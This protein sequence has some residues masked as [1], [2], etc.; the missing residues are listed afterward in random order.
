[1]PLLYPGANR[2]GAERFAVRGRT[3]DAS[4][5]RH[6]GDTGL[7]MHG[8]PAARGPWEVQQAGPVTVAATLDW[9]DPAFPFPHRVTVGVALSEQA[10]RLV[11][12]VSGDAPIAFGFHPYLRL[13]GV[14]R[15]GWRVELP[16]RRRLVLGD[17]RLP[18][19]ERTDTRPYAGPLGDRTYD[20]AFEAPDAPFALEGGGRR[21]E[22]VFEQGFPYCQVFAPADDDVV[23]FE[24]MTA[25]TNALVTG[26]DLQHAPYEAAFRIAVAKSR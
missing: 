12:R 1:V 17:R 7:P 14:A 18:T 8:L 10:L 21:I 9:D 26:D 15:A 25:P 24:P 13:P 5:A 19:G 23:A 20:D 22:V 6:D 11:V 3:V 4:G 16:V 2:V